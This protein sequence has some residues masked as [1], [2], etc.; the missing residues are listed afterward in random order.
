MPKGGGVSSETKGR[1]SYRLAFPPPL[2]VGFAG[3]A[4]LSKVGLGAVVG[5]CLGKS[6]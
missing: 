1:D 6:A 2:T 5:L 3:G 4:L